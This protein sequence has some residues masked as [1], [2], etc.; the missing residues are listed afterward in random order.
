MKRFLHEYWVWILAPMLVVAGLLIAVVVL[1][2]S[3]PV[4]PFVYTF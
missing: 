4:G 2:D 3:D 1:T